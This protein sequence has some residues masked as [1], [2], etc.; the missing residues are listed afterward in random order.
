LKDHPK[1]S[2]DH[3]AAQGL[4]S[5]GAFASIALR[6]SSGAVDKCSI[7]WIISGTKGELAVEV[8]ENSTWSGGQSDPKFQIRLGKE[9]PKDVDYKSE[10]FSGL[11]VAPPGSNVARVYQAFAANETSQYANFEQALQTHKLLERIRADSGR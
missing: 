5:S 7:R 10:G 6:T 11:N 9:E 1:T 2:P 3:I 4:L 8:D